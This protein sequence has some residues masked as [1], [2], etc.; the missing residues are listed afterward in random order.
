MTRILMMASVLAIS[1]VA[2][3]AHACKMHNHEQAMSC[4][5]GTVYDSESKTCIPQTSS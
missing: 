5:E 3:G 4:G 1:T 2:T